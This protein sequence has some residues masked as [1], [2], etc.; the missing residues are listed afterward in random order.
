L[1]FGFTALFRR[2]SPHR[3]EGLIFGERRFEMN[4]L[5]NVAF[6]RGGKKMHKK[7]KKF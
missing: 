7:H 6:K 5:D 4:I 3:S 2:E 1:D